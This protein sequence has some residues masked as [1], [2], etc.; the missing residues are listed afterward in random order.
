[1]KSVALL[2]IILSFSV[3]ITTADGQGFRGSAGGARSSGDSM[4]SAPT[5]FQ[6]RQGFVNT[7]GAAAAPIRSFAPTQ[8]VQTQS[9]APNQSFASTQTVQ[10]PSIAP[11]PVHHPAVLSTHR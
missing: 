8:S 5:A 9:I 11:V 10:T 1:M 7:P 3:G 6:S 2:T 4:Q